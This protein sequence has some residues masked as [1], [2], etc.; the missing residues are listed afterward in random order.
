MWLFQN[1]QIISYPPFSFSIQCGP[2]SDFP[3]WGVKLNSWAILSCVGSSSCPFSVRY[4]PPAEEWDWCVFAA[5]ALP[6]IYRKVY[7]CISAAIHSKVVRVRSRVDRRNREPPKRYPPPPPYPSCKTYWS[8]FAHLS[9]QCGLPAYILH[10]REWSLLHMHIWH[11]GYCNDLSVCQVRL[12]HTV[13]VGQNVLT[14]WL[15]H[16]SMIIFACAVFCMEQERPEGFSLPLRQIK[17]SNWAKA[18]WT[19]K[20]L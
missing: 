20:F 12:S 5:Y 11:A 14:I 4:Q 6:K 18:N 16:G 13:A 8:P 7:Y 9:G 19:S 15:V 17:S 10:T 1:M 3:Q 2:F